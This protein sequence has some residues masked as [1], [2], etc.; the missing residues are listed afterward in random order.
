MMLLRYLNQ[1]KISQLKTALKYTGKCQKGMPMKRNFPIKLI[2]YFIDLIFCMIFL[3][4]PK[5]GGLVYEILGY[6][7]FFLLMYAITLPA[8]TG[9]IAV[10]DAIF[11]LIKKKRQALL[12]SLLSGIIGIGLVATYPF[13][14]YYSSF[15]TVII[16]FDVIMILGCWIYW[17]MTWYKKIK[18]KDIE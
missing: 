12:Y 2:L 6:F 16:L 14:A 11:Q 18:S 3:S 4:T 8:L 5:I 15:F 9:I 10:I 1:R 13:W 7:R 17:L